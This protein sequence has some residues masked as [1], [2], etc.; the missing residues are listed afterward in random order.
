MRRYGIYSTN[1]GGTICR[2][3]KRAISGGGGR[4]F[5]A[6]YCPEGPFGA[7]GSIGT[8]K[9]RPPPP[10]MALFEGRQIVTP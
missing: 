5:L 3:S 8:A 6:S 4:P 7:F 1:W 2:P 10:E 9:G